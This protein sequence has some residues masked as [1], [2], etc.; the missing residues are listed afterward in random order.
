MDAASIRINA[1]TIQE[2]AGRIVR[3]VGKVTNVERGS[4]TATI[5]AGGPIELSFNPADNVET[6]KI[7]EFIGKAG[8]SEPKINVYAFTQFSDNTNL[9]A[10]NKLARFVL[11][12]P[13]LFY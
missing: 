10:A 1:Q 9:Q 12:T 5:D 4:D 8:V 6:G 2:Y 13:E 7:Y 3:V 11:K